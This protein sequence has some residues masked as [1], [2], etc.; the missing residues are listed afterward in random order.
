MLMG[1]ET[2][3]VD[4]VEVLIANCVLCSFVVFIL[5]LFFS[6]LVWRGIGLY[7]VMREESDMFAAKS[8]GI[9]KIAGYKK[10]WLREREKE[11]ERGI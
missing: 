7:W 11:G 5:F 1:V 2:L 3:E 10:G 9:W 6:F 8:E 4:N